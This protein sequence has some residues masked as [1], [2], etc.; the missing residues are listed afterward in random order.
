M[1]YLIILLLLSGC[2]AR[3]IQYD[4]KK[5][6]IAEQQVDRFNNTERGLINEAKEYQ[7]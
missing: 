6:T 4:I 3:P 5:Q 1:K 7:Q 2:I